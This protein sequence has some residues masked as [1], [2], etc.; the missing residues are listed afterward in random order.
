MVFVSSSTT[1]VASHMALTSTPLV[2]I[3]PAGHIFPAVDKSS[4]KLGCLLRSGCHLLD[5]L[6]RPLTVPAKFPMLDQLGRPLTIL[7]WIS[8]TVPARAS[9]H[10]SSFGHPLLDQL[11]CPLTVPN[12]TTPQSALLYAFNQSAI[13]ALF[14]LASRLLQCFHPS[15]FYLCTSSLPFQVHNLAGKLSMRFCKVRDELAYI[16]MR[17]ML[18]PPKRPN[19]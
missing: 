3:L 14:Q 7:A 19:E 5:Q 16:R 1:H 13:N 15:R 9:P 2:Q 10:C 11:G 12:W 18:S 6:E 8:S 4:E 17:P